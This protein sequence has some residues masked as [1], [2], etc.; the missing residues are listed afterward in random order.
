[1]NNSFTVAGFGEVMMRLSPEGFL[2]F[3]QALPGRLQ[4]IFG[5]G[6]A[7]V[8]A[9]LAQFGINARYLT[10]LPL[11]PIADALVAELRGLGVDTTHI[12]RTATGRLGIYFAETGASQRASTVIYDRA[13]SALAE[14]TAD[15]YDFDSMLQGVAWLH[16]SGITPAVSSAA[17]QANFALAERAVANGVKISLDLNFRKKLWRW[18]AGKSP[19]DLARREMTCLA[20]LADVLIANEEDA[21]EVFGIEAPGT[22]IEAG[23]LSLDGYVEVARRLGASFPKAKYIAFTLRESKSASW[24]NWGAMLYDVGTGQA[25]S[26]PLAPDGSYHPYE[27]RSIVDRIGGGDSFCAGLIYALNT[28]EW[29]APERAIAFATAASCLKH[30][31]LGDYNRVTVTEVAALANGNASGRVSR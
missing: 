29:S 22:A 28:P 27:I 26:A 12:L 23:K 11:N 3:G 31:I 15:E 1:M 13:H 10:A 17:C 19:R 30:S 14:T 16:L 21:R 20:A 5:G 2:R 18:D 4:A 24:N 25:H 7:N 9:S 8:C 6:E